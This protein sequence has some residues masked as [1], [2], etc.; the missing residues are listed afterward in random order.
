MIES[1]WV[2]IRTSELIGVYS[3]LIFKNSVFSRA[4]EVKIGFTERWL[5]SRDKIIAIKIIFQ[6]NKFL[7]HY[8]TGKRQIYFSKHKANLW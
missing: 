5:N 8:C 2:S 4:K 7:R 1:I 6:E 3:M